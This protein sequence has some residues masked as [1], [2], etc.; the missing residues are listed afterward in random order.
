MIVFAVACG[1]AS[2]E[3]Q[4]E[5]EKV[6]VVVPEAIDVRHTKEYDGGVEYFV[7]DPFPGSIVIKGIAERLRLAGWKETN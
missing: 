6:L 5:S 7:N 4:L 3:R 1:A 2:S